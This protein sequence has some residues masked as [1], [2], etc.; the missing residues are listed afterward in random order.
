MLIKKLRAKNWACHSALDL[1]FKPGLNGILGP[2]GSGKSS[3][4]DALRFGITGETLAAGQKSDNIRAGQKSGFVEVDFQHGDT[5]YSVRRHAEVSKNKLSFSDQVMTRGTDIAEHLES[6]LQTKIDAL[7]NNVFVG[8][9]A[10]DDILFK[11]NTERLREFQET[12]GLTRMA[13]AYRVLTAEISSCTITPGLEVQRNLLLEA[14]KQSRLDVDAARSEMA[15]LEQSIAVLVKIAE[16]VVAHENMVYAR[17]AYDRGLAAVQK[18]DKEVAD[19]HETV[20]RLRE[21][22]AE[23]EVQIASQS[24]SV[25][26][27]MSLIG[28]HAYVS[29]TR[30]S[31][32]SELGSIGSIPMPEGNLEELQS[33]VSRAHDRLQKLTA[34]SRG[35]MPLPRLPDDDAVH[36]E[37]QSV[38]SSLNDASSDGPI[39]LL[40]DTYQR[41]QHTLQTFSSG[42]CPTC[43]RPLD[44][45]DPSHQRGVVDRAKLALDT[46]VAQRD[47]HRR[48]LSLRKAEL[49]SSIDSRRKAGMQAV[50]AALAESK[51]QYTQLSEK[52]KAFQKAS[53]LYDAAQT[54]KKK[55]VQQLADMPTVTPEELLQAKETVRKSEE[56]V[57]RLRELKSK[58]MMHTGTLA[59]VSEERQRVMSTLREVDSTAIMTPEDYAKAK[60]SE[61]ELQKQFAAKRDLETRIGVASAK[62]QSQLETIAQLNQQID[63]ES[64]SAKWSRM[65]EKAREVL[66]VSG[67]PSLLMK[68]YA[69]RINRR[70]ANYLQVWEAPF[71]LYLDDTL[72]FKAAFDEGYELPAARLSGG[73]KIVASTSFRL[74]MS[75]TFAKNVGLLILDEPTNHLD[76]ENVVHLQ[77]LLVKLKQC[78]GT[79]QRQIIIVTHEEQLIN[80]FDHT[81]KLDKVG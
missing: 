35:E 32:E 19:L 23:V 28:R 54:R 2:N 75:D 61:V 30:I 1:E 44:G 7:L 74:A 73:Q 53:A 81:I 56:L 47:D 21:E 49:E 60:L 65:C 29:G 69:L 11:T 37:L 22:T 76:R 46:A 26:M 58:H 80:F 79:S 5:A 9:H 62:L 52:V 55:L 68:E 39:S 50:N 41:E 17:E 51:V 18:L 40:R 14:S 66:H 8:Q 78:V 6:V 33:D 64:K 59:R 24:D 16:R 3:V 10:I 34:I 20:S 13:E 63:R 38:L 72:S 27:A 70:I 4:L 48:L 71:R 57:E 42:S 31:L 67:L 15:A 77:Q 25:Q 12:F 36:A 45:F 43:L